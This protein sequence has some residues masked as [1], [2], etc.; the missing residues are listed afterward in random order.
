MEVEE[1]IDKTKYIIT[2]IL[3]DNYRKYL[4]YI[5]IDDV[6]KEFTELENKIK[7]LRVEH[8]GGQE[9]VKLFDLFKTEY[10]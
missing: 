6:L 10:F 2:H 3:L 1:N 5:N 9:W 7:D 8:L 4:D